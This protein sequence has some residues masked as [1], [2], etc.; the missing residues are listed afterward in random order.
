MTPGWGGAMPVP[1]AV[2]PG[3]E[4]PCDAGPRGG[5]M[6]GGGAYGADGE[7]TPGGGA[8]GA[9][10]AGGAYCACAADGDAAYGAGAPG[11]GA[12]GTAMPGAVVAGA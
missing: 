4:A 9:D 12:C 8:Y 6:L 2:L 1:G 5:C 11:G 10:G 3:D 7:G